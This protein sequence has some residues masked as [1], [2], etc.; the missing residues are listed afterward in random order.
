[1]NATYIDYLET[2][3]D[4]AIALVDDKEQFTYGELRHAARQIATVLQAQYG[5]RQYLI[6]RATSESRFVLTLLGIMYSGN[7]PIPVD[8][9][10]PATTL[11]YMQDK[12]GAVAILEPL[13]PSD[14]AYATPTGQIEAAMPALIMF[15]SGTTGF[16]KGVIISQANLIHSCTAMSNYLD[17]HR[18]RSAAVVLPLY[19]SYALLS[20]VCCQLFV[21]GRVRLFASF[22]NPIKFSRVVNEEE[23][24]TFC[25]VPST[26]H[27]LVMV[28]RLTPLRMPAVQVLCSAGAAMDRSKW[29][30]IKDIFPN[31]LFFNNY[32]MTEAAPR[33]AYIREDDPRFFEPTCGR[34]MAGVE[35][36]IVDPDT[37]DELPAGQAGMLV[38]RGP[39]VTQGYLH[40]EETTRKAFTRH[41]YLISGDMAFIDQGYLFICGRYDD[42]FNVGGE[43]VAPLE[44]ERLLHEHP[45]VETA[46][47]TGVPDAARGMV[48]VAFVKLRGPLTKKDLLQKLQQELPPIKIPQRFLE[49]RDFPMTA[50]GKLQRR[51]LSPDDPTYVIRE[52]D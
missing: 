7:T 40:D 27:A 22:R 41:G 5:T 11:Q 15:T 52:I 34:P 51:M 19:Y 39:N 18:H 10:S 16:P 49:V 42:I 12:S 24:A 13:W 29:R 28:H 2:A 46:A 36:K 1:M 32:G 43:K 20:Q 6:L 33:I 9:A 31:A 35:V 47:V 14:F 50:N 48:P 3:H 26:Y 44:I 37:H 17:Y 23:L 21:G 25:G 4:N 45:L 38:V 8:S 30:E